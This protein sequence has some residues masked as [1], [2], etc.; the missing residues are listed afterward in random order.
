MNILL[1]VAS[2]KLFLDYCNHA[3]R[4]VRSLGEVPP[5]PE[6]FKAKIFYH[7]RSV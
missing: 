4:A 1:V 2:F 5:P 6:I 7:H 3:P